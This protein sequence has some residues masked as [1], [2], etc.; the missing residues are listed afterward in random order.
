M[1][2]K[3]FFFSIFPRTNTKIL[4]HFEYNNKNIVHENSYILIA[5]AKII[6]LVLK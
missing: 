5:F 1:F 4:I 6:L 3:I 2:L